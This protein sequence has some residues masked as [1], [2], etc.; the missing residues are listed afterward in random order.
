[1]HV[2]RIRMRSVGNPDVRQF[3]SVSFPLSVTATHLS[4]IRVAVDRYIETWELGAGNWPRCPVRRDG[5]V[6][7]HFSYN[8]RFWRTKRKSSR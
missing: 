1:M 7:G 4:T 6:I 5:K 2:Y 8:R 3:A